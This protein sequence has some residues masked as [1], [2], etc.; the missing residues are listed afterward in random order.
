MTTAIISTQQTI[1]AAVTTDS[2]AVIAVIYFLVRLSVITLLISSPPIAV[3]GFTLNP[4]ISY[5][6]IPINA[7]GLKIFR[8]Y[9]KCMHE[10][11]KQSEKQ[12]FIA[13]RSFQSLCANYIEYQKRNTES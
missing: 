8:L 11:C 12:L 4:I 5:H 9:A 6:E 2:I 3:F 1:I 7:I 13:F 10:L